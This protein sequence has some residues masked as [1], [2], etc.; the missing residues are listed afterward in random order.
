MILQKVRLVKIATDDGR[1][2][3]HRSIAAGETGS[4]PPIGFE[5]LVRANSWSKRALGRGT[6]PMMSVFLE[7]GLTWVPVEL[8]DFTNE[9]EDRN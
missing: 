9:Y 3:L 2:D 1:F 7:D 5:F 6:L 4:P 8:L